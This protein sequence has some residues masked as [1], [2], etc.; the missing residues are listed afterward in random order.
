MD[1]LPEWESFQLTYAVLPSFQSEYGVH[2]EC[3]HGEIRLWTRNA[4]SVG[5]SYGRNPDDLEG[6]GRVLPQED[7]FRIMEILKRIRITAFALGDL[8]L[9]GVSYRLVLSHG[10]NR[11]ELDWW[12]NLPK[13]WRGIQPLQDLLEGYASADG[14]GPR[15]EPLS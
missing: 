4:P 2:L 8:G 7:A 15:A 12:M 13:G 10:F 3:K 9:D 1:L 6:P 11:L 5:L 14:E